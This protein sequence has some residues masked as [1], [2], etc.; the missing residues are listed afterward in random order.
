[1]KSVTVKV[2]L[3]GEIPHLA[4]YWE[5]CLYIYYID[6]MHCIFTCVPEIVY[7]SN[8]NYSIFLYYVSLQEYFLYEYTH[9]RTFTSFTSRIYYILN[10]R[11]TVEL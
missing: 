11:P 3:Y 5:I 1:M 10:S 6:T 2:C 8:N 7:N 4:E 9:I